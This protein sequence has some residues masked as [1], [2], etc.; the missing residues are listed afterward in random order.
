M[1]DIAQGRSTAQPPASAQTTHRAAP[2]SQLEPRF[3][4]SVDGGLLSRANLLQFM[5]AF[6]RASDVERGY[7]LEFGVLNGQSL[8]ETYGILRGLLTH[9][10][11]F[12]SFTGLPKLSDTDQVSLSLMPSF[13]EGNFKSLSR[14]AIV[15][16]VLAA[17]SGLSSNQLTLV[18][19][20]Y[21]DTLSVFDTA[22]FAD[23]GPC[24][25]AHVDCDLYSSS[26]DVFA[27]LDGIV[28]TGTWLLLDDYWHYHGSPRHGQRRAFEEWMGASK[29]IGATEYSNY[30]GFCRAYVLYEK[31]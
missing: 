30:N 11:G 21:A 4:S 13:S 24:L 16:Y 12:D 3:A 2:P 17:T 5:R 25:V 31:E 6:F 1:T 28:T 7:Y 27:F 29:R 10:Y 8:I 22:Q 15:D 23:K 14:G 18:E 20:V 26:R 19:G 9:L